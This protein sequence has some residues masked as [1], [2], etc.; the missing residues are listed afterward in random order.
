MCEFVV[1]VHRETIEQF[2]TTQRLIYKYLI[3]F[4][5]SLLFYYFLFVKFL[6]FYIIKKEEISHSLF[7]YTDYNIVNNC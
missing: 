3:I 1:V 4:S 7:F 5:S 6:S 2:K